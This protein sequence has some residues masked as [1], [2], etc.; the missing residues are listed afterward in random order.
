MGRQAVRAFRSESGIIT[1]DTESHPFDFDA[2]AWETTEKVETLVGW[3]QWTS[4]YRTSDGLYT[5][6][7]AVEETE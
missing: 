6:L 3:G 2:V 1:L 7:Y 4:L 5:K